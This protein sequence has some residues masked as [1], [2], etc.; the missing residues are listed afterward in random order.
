M[1]YAQVVKQELVPA[2]LGCCEVPSEF[3]PDRPGSG[4]GGL[5]FFLNKHDDYD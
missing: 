2:E 1:T 4:E 5:R 3:S